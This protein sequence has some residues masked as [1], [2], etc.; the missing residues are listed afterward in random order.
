MTEV[1]GRL[2]QLGSSPIVSIAC[3]PEDGASP[4]LPL[5][6]RIP[7]LDVVLRTDHEIPICVRTYVSFVM[8]EVLWYPIL[9]CLA[10]M[11]ILGL[12]CMA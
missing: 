12:R 4:T 3:D 1:A 2:R 10:K 9:L 6:L 8:D 7:L 11:V 5:L